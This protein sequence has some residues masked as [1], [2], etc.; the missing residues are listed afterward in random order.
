MRTKAKVK[1]NAKQEFKC[2]CQL[3]MQMHI[4]NAKASPNA[5][6]DCGCKYTSWTPK[7]KQNWIGINNGNENVNHEC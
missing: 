2:S 3:W 7:Q 5:N 6:H 4:M 1:E